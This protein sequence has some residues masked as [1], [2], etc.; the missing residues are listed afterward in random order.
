MHTSVLWIIN[1]ENIVKLPIKFSAMYFSPCHF[2]QYPGVPWNTA[3]KY[4]VY[5]VNMTPGVHMQKTTKLQLFLSKKSASKWVLSLSRSWVSRGRKFQVHL[6][7]KIVRR[8]KLPALEGT[9]C[10]S[11]TIC[12][13]LPL[14]AKKQY[15]KTLATK[16]VQRSKCT[17]HL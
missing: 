12:L 7:V 10:K 8:D 6:S 11:L 1:R 2:C 5:I 13:K 9:I 4:F 14:K 16:C 15:A 3:P 17:S